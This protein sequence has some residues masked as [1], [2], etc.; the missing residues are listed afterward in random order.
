[1]EVKNAIPHETFVLNNGTLRHGF[2]I[3]LLE[4]ETSLKFTGFQE[5]LRCTCVL[6]DD[7][8]ADLKNCAAIGWGKL[9][10]NGTLA[11]VLQEVKFAANDHCSD[12]PDLNESGVIKGMICAGGYEQTSEQVFL[13][14]NFQNFH[15]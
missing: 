11:T 6:K 8:N 9:K 1:M 10:R 14:V 13:F 3:G 12:Y 5:N 4:L 15:C 7:K 2:D